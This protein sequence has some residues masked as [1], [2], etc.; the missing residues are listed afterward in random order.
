MAIK[1]PRKLVPTDKGHADVINAPIMT[2]YE[3][4]QELATQVESIKSDP[5][6]NGVASKEEL[7]T[8]VAN[9][10]LHVTAAK[11]A[12]WN[13]AQENAELY[14][15]NYA[16]PKA[17]THPASDLPSATT[18]TRGITKLNNSVSSPATDEAATANAVKQ[19]Y[20]EATAAKQLGVE[21]KTNVVA[22]LNSIGIS[23]STSE[24]WTQLINKMAGV[25]RATG[26]ATAAQVLTGAT[27]SNASGNGRTGTMPNR[28]GGSHN[29]ALSTEVWQGDR[30]FFRAPDGYFD[31]QSWVY[32]H[33][34]DLLPANIRSGKNVLGVVG[35]LAAGVSSGSTR[36]AYD[37]SSGVPSTY[38]TAPFKVR[39]LTMNTGGTYRVSFGIRAE[40]QGLNYAYGQLYINGVP[41]GIQRQTSLGDVMYY[42]EDLAIN[43]G[44]ILQLYIWTSNSSYRAL[45]FSNM[46]IYISDLTSEFR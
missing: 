23:A 5:G 44:E 30:T 26:N 42:T 27:F 15:R 24:S 45:Y 21:Q 41:R 7:D 13:K 39:E 18:Q 8:H 28:G 11:Q 32:A 10:E 22:A 4:D 1:E 12:V 38:N 46:S 20:D 3:N 37:P 6:A 14:T 17:H 36:I 2:L 9:T 19:A 35:T 34:P 25:I 43:A 29:Q 16:A 31:G 40:G 33:T